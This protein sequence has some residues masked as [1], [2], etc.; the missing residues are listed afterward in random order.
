MAQG[1]Q[2]SKEAVGLAGKTYLYQMLLDAI[3]NGT[4]T[5]VRGVELCRASLEI[6]N[7]GPSGSFSALSLKLMGS[8]ALNKPSDGADGFQ[9][10]ADITALGGVAITTP[11]RWYK[12]KVVTCTPSGAA[13]LSALLHG[14]NY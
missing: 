3:T 14:L 9:I 8:N 11:A 4:G 13:K 5:W 6:L 10:G 12:V 2:L 7:S 1:E